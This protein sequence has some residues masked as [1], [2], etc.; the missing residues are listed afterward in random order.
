MLD[1]RTEVVRVG[2]IRVV[3]RD[4]AA[5]TTVQDQV[6][7]AVTH[8]TGER[9]TW[10]D[11]VRAAGPAIPVTLLDGFDELLQA[12]GIHQSDYL[13]RVAEFQRREA[14]QGR[15]VA[16]IAELLAV[17][18]NLGMMMPAPQQHV[19]AAVLGD[20][21]HVVAQHERYRARRAKLR[22]ALEGAGYTIEHSEASLYLW[23]TKGPDGPD[24]WQLVSD[25]ADLGILVAPGAFYGAAGSHHVRIGLT[26][27]DERID[28]AVA[29]LG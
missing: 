24:A 11:L 21:D 27:T 8:A 13:R 17:R 18:K 14:V 19:M 3:L 29:R 9:L 1:A 22:A 20:Q 26:G 7:A 23:T 4:V 16:V 12:T 28:A 5:D 6:E 25:L 2:K 10:P 15:P